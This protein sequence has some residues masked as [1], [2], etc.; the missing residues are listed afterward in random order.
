MCRSPGNCE[1]D[2]MVDVAKHGQ[3]S[4]KCCSETFLC[5]AKFVGGNVVF[6]NHPA[7]MFLL[8]KVCTWS[9][10]RNRSVFFVSYKDREIT[11]WYVGFTWQLPCA[12]YHSHLPPVWRRCWHDIYIDTSIWVI[13]FGTRTWSGFCLLHISAVGVL[14]FVRGT[15]YPYRYQDIVQALALNICGTS[16]SVDSLRVVN[17]AIRKRKKNKGMMCQP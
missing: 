16:I 8:S 11:V 2:K 1:A 6:I 17:V 15:V 4:A 14:A 5:T 7:F 3:N 12:D 13:Q 9:Y 10:L